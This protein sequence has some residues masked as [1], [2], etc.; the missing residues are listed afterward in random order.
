M[1]KAKT[2]KKTTAKKAEV[3]NIRKGALAYVGLYGLAYER[4]QM[5]ADQL[6]TASG[7][8]F[9]TLVKK[10][11]VLETKGLELTKDTRAKATDMVETSVETVKNVVP[12]G[13]R[14]NRVEELEAEVASLNKKISA[15]SK[16]ATTTRKMA[17]TATVK[18][19][20]AKVEATKTV[21]ETPATTEKKAA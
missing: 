3:S 18:A 16:K 13:G 21:A 17:K 5:R 11:A 7:E 10:G 4:A 15:L 20:A 8:L 12:F 1:A 6:K 14:D 2:T 19:T 9:N